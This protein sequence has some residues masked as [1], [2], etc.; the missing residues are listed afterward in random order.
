MLYADTRHGRIEAEPGLQGTCP[1]CA[2]PMVAKC[3]DIVSW[4]WAHTTTENCDPWSSGEGEWHRGWKRRLEV[5]CGAKSEPVLTRHG[6]THRADSMLPNGLVVEYQTNY[7]NL[8]DI[9]AREHFYG[10]MLWIYRCEYSWE[11]IHFGK[12]GFWWKH[13]PAS[14]TRHNRPIFIEGPDGQFLQVDKLDHVPQR[15]RHCQWPTCRTACVSECEPDSHRVLG[16]GRIIDLDQLIDIIAVR[17]GLG[18]AQDQPLFT[19][20]PPTRYADFTR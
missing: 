13:G 5:R 9:E 17:G 14:L 10:S 18:P 4:H 16:T 6:Q 20:A 12:R 8:P 2:T 11:R 15:A 1:Q 19:E 3:G 7:L